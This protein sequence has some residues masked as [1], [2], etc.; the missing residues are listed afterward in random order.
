KI[1]NY[2]KQNNPKSNFDETDYIKER[3][4]KKVEVQKNATSYQSSR[5]FQNKRNRENR[6]KKEQDKDKLLE[7][8]KL[9]LL[10]KTNIIAE[11]DKLLE[12]LRSEIEMLRG[13]DSSD[14]SSYEEKINSKRIRR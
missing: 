10:E 7:A 1:A 3:M 4:E 2:Q 14:D 9:E 11:K 12:E 8:L 6:K 5:Y 13:P